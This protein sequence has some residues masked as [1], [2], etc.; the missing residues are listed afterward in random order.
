MAQQ[1]GWEG[2]IINGAIRD[3]EA[4]KTIDIGIK[5]LAPCPRR[6]K[7]HGW[8]ESNVSVT[9]GEETFIPGEWLVADADG[10]VIASTPL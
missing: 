6:S 7:K 1:N 10:I 8:G 9:F 3:V 5:A 2:I 4:L